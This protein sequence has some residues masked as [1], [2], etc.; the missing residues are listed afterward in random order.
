MSITICNPIVIIIP[1]SPLPI[2]RVAME[3]DIY[4]AIIEYE[5]PVAITELSSALIHVQGEIH[6]RGEAT[7]QL[8]KQ[9]YS[10]KLKQEPAQGNFLGMSGGGKHWVFNDC[11]AVDP[12]LIRN[13]FAFALQR[14]MEQYASDYTY[15]ELYICDPGTDIHNVPANLDKYYHGTYLNFEKIRF[16]SSSINLPYDKNKSTDD[17]AI[18]QLNQ[19]SSKYYQFPLNPPLTANV[20]IY[21]PADYELSSALKS[22]FTSWYYD[23]NSN[24]WAGNFATAYNTYVLQQ[25]PI[26]ESIFQEI[27]STTDYKSF[28]TYFL[29]NELA[30]DPDGYHKSTFMVKNKLVVKAGPLWDKNKSFGNAATLGTSDPYVDP[31]GWLFNMTGQ[32]PI[33]WNILIK[34]P[35]FCSEVWNQWKTYLAPTTGSLNNDK[36]WLLDFIDLQYNYLF[37][38]TEMQ[39]RDAKRWPD[40]TNTPTAYQTQLTELKTYIN[41]RILWISATI[42]NFL[43]QESGAQLT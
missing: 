36:S 1:G 2:T 39:Q 13:P 35:E 22:S 32:A 18:L 10:V 21:E 5:K 19:H 16:D 15:F 43:E 28:A 7:A 31:Q 40:T 11:G 17:Y 26:P 20:E 37:K 34:D 24:G 33:W 6:I 14:K 38:Q 3:V 29:I 30:K 4:Y 42:K 23:A 12:T 25:K 41:Q 8:P 9:Q 27:R